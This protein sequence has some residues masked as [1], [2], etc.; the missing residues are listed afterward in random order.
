M[1]A[2][3]ETRKGVNGRM[4]LPKVLITLQDGRVF[5]G[6][7]IS[8]DRQAHC[9]MVICACMH[10]PAV[11]AIYLSYEAMT[12][13]Q[14]HRAAVSKKQ[15]CNK[16]LHQLKPTRAGVHRQLAIACRSCCIA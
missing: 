13:R 16:V 6:R 1:S 14:E 9:E 2:A 7:V 11:H 3:A 8:S 15:H 12:I 4:Q 10:G 5:Q